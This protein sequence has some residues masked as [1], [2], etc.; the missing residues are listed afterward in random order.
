MNFQVLFDQFQSLPSG[1]DSFKQLKNQCEHAIKTA[2]NPLQQNALFLI[3]GFAKNYVLLYEDEAVTASFAQMA[4]AQ[5]LQYMQQLNQALL[6]QD[7]ALILDALNKI[8]QH[9]MQSSRVF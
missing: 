4:K 7:K 9:Y 8:T 3:Y 5:L 6:T 1:T 2:N